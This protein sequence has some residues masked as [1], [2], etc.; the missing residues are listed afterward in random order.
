M[1]I[2]LFI[3]YIYIYIIKFESS[4]QRM[5]TKIFYLNPQ[6]KEKCIFFF[7]HIY[8]DDTSSILKTKRVIKIFYGK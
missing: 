3:I 7:K 8:H 1:S 2:Y 4:N 5:H 6:I